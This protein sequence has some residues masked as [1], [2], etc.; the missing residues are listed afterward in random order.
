VTST[1]ETPA[2]Q[3]PPAGWYPDPS[4]RHHY[5]FFTGVDWTADVVDDGVHSTDPLPSPPGA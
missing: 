1:G 4:G 3:S 2:Q 5:R